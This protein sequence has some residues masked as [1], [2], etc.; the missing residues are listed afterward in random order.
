[1][2]PLSMLMQIHFDSA[3]HLSAHY[4]LAGSFRVVRAR[5]SLSGW[6]IQTHTRILDLVEFLSFAI[7]HSEDVKFT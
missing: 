2:R 7:E 1:M 4:A 3:V 6:A 5:T